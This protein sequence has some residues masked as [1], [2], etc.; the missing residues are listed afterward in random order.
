MAWADAV[1]AFPNRGPAE[2]DEIVKDSLIDLLDCGY[3]FFFRYSDFDDEFRPRSPVDGLPREDV[4]E[5]LSSGRLLPENYD[6]VSPDR[7]MT[8][9]NPSGARVV[10]AEV[11]AFRATEAGERRHAELSEDDYRI[12][13]R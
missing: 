4:A 11:L 8:T 12:F 9:A 1:D 6:S 5:V 7:A 10:L 2:V 3:L 13:G